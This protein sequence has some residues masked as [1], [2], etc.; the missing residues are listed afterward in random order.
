MANESIAMPSVTSTLTQH[1]GPQAAMSVS[2]PIAEG[3]VELQAGVEPTAKVSQEPSVHIKASASRTEKAQL[4]KQ[5]QELQEKLAN[6]SKVKG[7]T[8]DFT[9]MPEFDQPVV[10]VIDADTRQVIRQIPS[11]EILLMKKRLQAME[12]GGSDSVNLSG[13]LFDGQV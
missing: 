8:L 11:E 12:Q 6:L 10:K 3:R 9:L 7:W 13:L 4:E 5:A 2:P 1:G